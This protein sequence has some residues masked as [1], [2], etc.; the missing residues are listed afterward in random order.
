MT[1]PRADATPSADATS[2]RRGEDG[3]LAKTE[4]IA[5]RRRWR[6][7]VLILFVAA[8][9]A[10]LVWVF[11]PQHE[12][13][14]ADWLDARGLELNAGFSGH[15]LPGTVVRTHRA[16]AEGK[17][18]KLP[19]P[20]IELWPD[21]CFP[22][23]KPRE[24]SFPLPT[25]GGKR[26]TALRLGGDTRRFLPSLGTEGAKSWQIEITRPRTL[27]FAKADLALRVSDSCLDRLEQIFDAGTEPASMAMILEA[28]VADGLKITVDW[29][30]G[31]DGEGAARRTAE[32]ME[33]EEVA[34][35]AELGAENK[36]VLEAQGLVVVAYRVAAL[37]PVT[38]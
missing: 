27:T 33:S 23:K 9:A 8:A 29:R 13:D 31:V 11:Q 4:I 22:G 30:A 3:T 2:S 25:G 15:Y 37:V 14:L 6:L 34:V 7:Q 28:V 17:P 10:A 36:T 24:A 21:R 32:Q 19:R 16:D 1:E 35:K 5:A 38:D 20:E 18:Q 12:I 26:S